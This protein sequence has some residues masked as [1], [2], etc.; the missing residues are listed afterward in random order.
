MPVVQAGSVNTTAQ[1]VPNLLVQIVPPSVS[2]LN[3][4][5][6]DILGV[7]GTA[8][9]GPV[10]APVPVSTMA[11][12]YDN[13]GAIQTNKYDMG[14]AVAAAVL[15][16]ANNL[17]CVRVTDGTDTAAA[18]V[19]QTSCITFTAKYS[20]SR[21][22]SLQVTIASGSKTG[23]YKA[24]VTLPGT[25]PE[26]FDNITGS[27]NALWVA[28]AAAINSGQSGQRGPS[29]LIVATAGVGTAAPTLATLS[30]SGGT[31]G[32]TTITASV[33][34]G[35]DTSPRTGMYALRGTSASLGMLADLDDSTTWANQVAFGLSE[36]I[37]M[38]LVGPAGE[39]IGDASTS[40]TAVYR[41]VN[42][43]VDSYTF[44]PLLGDWC[45]FNDTV[46]N[47]I[48]LVSPQGF[49]AGRLANL[50]P[51]QSGLNKPIYGIVA[52][53]R[54]QRGVPYSQAELTVL[55]QAGI[56]VITNP[57]PGGN[58]FGLRF[59]RNGSSNPVANGDNYT[60]MTNYLAY[61]LNA[62]MG[63]FV[64]QLQ[65]IGDKDETRRQ[66]SATLST[67]MQNLLDAG[68]IDSYSV[69]CNKSNNS[70]SRIALG[71]LQADVRVRY[72]AVIYVFIVNMEG[73]Q[74]VNVTLQGVEKA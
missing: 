63:R 54:S 5:P 57:V 28:M 14:T 55:G 65:T 66:V 43:G 13:F 17:R 47:Q 27:G 6:T 38:M 53:Q 50:G 7:V 35:V 49:A 19:V 70:D 60:R 52:T 40:G 12:Y 51:H 48:R 29:L 64:G 30:L 45:Y 1:I 69:V 39:A 23:T 37:Y 9:W 33:M 72:R 24:I 4:L 25:V 44:K 2:Q 71:Y 11:D 58:Y 42:A 56:D 16:G 62:G 46:N 67:F 68:Q 34:Q 31:D 21:G 74:S 15:Q 10:N 3:G 59:G 18:V 73:G 26:V 36:G 61:T 32:N 20:G 8:T 22:N 41:R